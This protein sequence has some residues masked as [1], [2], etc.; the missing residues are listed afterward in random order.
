M[1]WKYDL[2]SRTLEEHVASTPLA[3]EVSS[4]Y[5]Y[6]D[7]GGS[8]YI[9][10]VAQHPNAPGFEMPAL[11]YAMWKR[12]CGMDYPDWAMPGDSSNSTCAA[13]SDDAINVAMSNAI[14]CSGM[15]A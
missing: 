1:L 3:A 12:H 11:G 9:I 8:S 7:V 10:M 2:E 5:F 4:P 13:E 15:L 6:P 14:G